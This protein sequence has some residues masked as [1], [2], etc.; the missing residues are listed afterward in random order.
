[1]TERM[2]EERWHW[3]RAQVH[4]G[5]MLEVANELDRA[6]AREVE[7][8]RERDEALASSAGRLGLFEAAKQMPSG[9]FVSPTPL[10]PA[11]WISPEAFERAVQ[12]AREEVALV[13]STSNA[14][15]FSAEWQEE[16]EKDMRAALHPRVEGEED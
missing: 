2:S 13:A 5:W 11:G 14:D 16:I 3:L 7:L 4:T 15:E 9:V 8:E 6:R 10:A 1:M 12:A